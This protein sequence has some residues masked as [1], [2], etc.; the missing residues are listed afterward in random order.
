MRLLK[1]TCFFCSAAAIFLSLFC[2]TE[3]K[4]AANKL[5]TYASL[6]DTV[7]YA[8]MQTCRSCHSEIYESFMHT[9]M[10]SSFDA[11]SKQKS[12]ARFDV[13]AL[14]YDKEKDFY[15]KPFWNGDSLLL[16]EFRLSGKDTIYKRTET[17][18]FIV[19]S[20]QHT[21]SHMINTNG[22]FTQAPATYYT[23]KGSWDLPPGFED[24]NNSR[25]SRIIGLECMTC[26]NGYPDFVL[27]SENK[28]AAV[29]NG[30]D[31]ERCHGPGQTHAEQK[32]KG[33]LVDTSQE[34]D[35]TIVN[36]GKLEINLQFDVCQRCHIQGN[37]VLN[38]GKSFFDF[39][40]GM[41][42]SDVMNV[43][44]PVYKGH[45]DEHIMA[46][47]A[48]RLKMSSCYIET[49]EKT[50]LE[51]GSLRPYKNS[52]TC[53]TC[54]NPHVSV[55]VTETKKFNAV[56]SNCHNQDN[57]SICT[58]N[59]IVLARN[60]N[61][62]IKCHMEMS[63][64]TDIPHVKV[65]DHKIRIPQKNKNPN[66][67]KKFIGIACINNPGASQKSRADAFVAYYEKFGF[68]KS[69]L[70]SAENILKNITVSQSDF[71]HNFNSLVQLYFL[72]K[73]YE[74]VIALSKK[75][76]DPFLKLNKKLY[77][78]NDAWTCYRIAESFQNHDNLSEAI[79]WY[80]QAAMLAP[81]Q[82]DFQHKYATA[83]SLNGKPAEAKK[84]YEFIIAENPE[85]AAAYCNLGFIYL[86]EEK[87]PAKANALYDKALSLN[88]DY[89]QA[90]MNKAGLYI[91]QQNFI[92][93]KNI[94]KKLLLKHPGNMQ[95]NE[96]LKSI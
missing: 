54:H 39:R 80:R 48:E 51:K 8:G 23:Q 1:A 58:E 55:R 11:A 91:Y 33:M 13:H 70:D 4:P 89:E 92:E 3:K 73:D 6:S 34:I 18:H 82:L 86:T 49:M 53:V 95:A 22:Y 15:Y 40:P 61:N 74:K 41:R 62:C 24:G 26:H 21:N 57:H 7:K 43:Y 87:N 59:K 42:L 29:K 28:Y 81:F 2:N 79:K 45:E 5:T 90:L 56:C 47:H 36:P 32:S 27:G 67:I 94:L 46:S 88:P 77:S 66:A 25:F 37:A 14:I 76:K 75:L 96:I 31:C 16:M 12:S 69:A 19:G 71:D 50:P 85:Y 72:K 64:A 63:S 30:I 10:G 84:I 9:G 17:I 44:M 38:D 83:L 65:H 60:D 78:N 93:A 35:Y 20:G 68:D 52:L